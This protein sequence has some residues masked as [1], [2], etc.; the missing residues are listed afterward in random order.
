[1]RQKRT[2]K[3]KKYPIKRRFEPLWWCKSKKIDPKHLPSLDLFNTLRSIAYASRALAAVP[4]NYAQ[5]EKEAMTLV[6]GCLKSH[7]FFM[8]EYDHKPFE[9]IFES[10][11]LQPPYIYRDN[12]L[13]S[14]KTTNWC[15][16]VMLWVAMISFLV[17]M[18]LDL[19]AYIK[20]HE[21]LKSNQWNTYKNTPVL[22]D[23][24]Y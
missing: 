9:S 8:V 19:Q 3:E 6:F 5:I 24:F 14:R 15:L 1:M 13:S 11:N 12:I 16:L 23:S 22:C 7:Y 10:H 20:A 21:C 17:L 18:S 2:Y 4:R